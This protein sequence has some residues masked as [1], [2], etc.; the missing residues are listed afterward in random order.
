MSDPLADQVLALTPEYS[1]SRGW[2]PPDGG[3]VSQSTNVLQD[4]MQLGGDIL[5]QIL[6]G[7]FDP[8]ALQP[9]VDPNWQPEPPPP[10]P[11]LNLYKQDPL[12]NQAIG[13]MRDGATPR[14]AIITA[15][16]ELEGVT[17]DLEDEAVKADVDYLVGEAAKVQ[18]EVGELQA[19]NEQPQE[20][21]MIDSPAMEQAREMGMPTGSYT[22]EMLNPE[23]APTAEK[24]AA[25]Q[26][27]LD[28]R[29]REFQL[30]ETA[31]PQ[32][33]DAV[34]PL[35][36]RFLN[37]NTFGIGEGGERPRPE[38]RDTSGDADLSPF[39]QDMGEVFKQFEQL[40]IPQ[41][42]PNGAIQAI[43]N[44]GDAVVGAA[45]GVARGIGNYFGVGGN[46]AEGRW[47]P[48]GGITEMARRAGGNAGRAVAGRDTDEQR[49][50]RN[51]QTHRG[52]QDWD[53]M[54]AYKDASVQRGMSEWEAKKQR[55]RG[56]QAMSGRNLQRDWLL[57][58][59]SGLPGVR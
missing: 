54:K 18:S 44:P 12:M 27:S 52:I 4:R 40:G 35:V 16:F 46:E 11:T 1:I 48:G 2:Q 25:D 41:T 9:I 59:L 56:E 24:A 38:P 8:S 17:P 23:I 47:S 28:E 32:V 43:N 6:M 30:S 45:G 49:T 36:D 31:M 15:K 14:D 3:T 39:Q 22:P 7:S 57:Q 13:L 34:K 5:M 26:T 19:F 42:D 33:Q 29:A 55:A 50:A 51:R 10:T 53:A 58:T 21:P 20:P 37:G